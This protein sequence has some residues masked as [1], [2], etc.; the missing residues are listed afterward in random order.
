MNLTREVRNQRCLSLGGRSFVVFPGPYGWPRRPVGLPFSEVPSWDRFVVL[1][2]E[3]KG[4]LHVHVLIAA[5][6]AR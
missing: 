3:T 2:G 4:R 1:P 5:S 6:G